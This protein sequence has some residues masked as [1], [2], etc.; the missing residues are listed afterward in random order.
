MFLPKLYLSSRFE[1][2]VMPST[3]TSL[4]MAPVE[5]LPVKITA[6]SS[7]A[8]VHCR[9]IVRAS[10]R[11]RVVW[12]PVPEDSVCVLAYKGRTASRR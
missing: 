5:P 11:N 8:P 2:M 12:R 9:I 4:S 6:C 10:S 7:P 3:P 1:G